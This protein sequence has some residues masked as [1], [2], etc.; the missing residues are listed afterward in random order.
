MSFRA[1][2]DR[3]AKA[4]RIRRTMMNALP[5]TTDSPERASHELLESVP[6]PE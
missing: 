4:E 2:P 5:D 3:T 1:T 6:V